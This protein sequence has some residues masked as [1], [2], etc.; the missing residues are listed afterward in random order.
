MIKTLLPAI[1][2]VVGTTA[3]AQTHFSDDFNDVNLTG[4]SSTDN[5]ANV[6][7]ATGTNYDI[8]YAADMSSAFAQLG[9]GS[10]VS[11]SWANNI[12]YSP[13]NF[14]VSPAINLTAA[15]AAGLSLKW[16]VGSI[17]TTAS[18]WYQE[19]YAVYVSTSS[20]P[21]T[22][23][24]TAPVYEETL[25][26]GETMFG[27]TVDLSAF[28][29]QTIYVLFRHFNCTDENALVL[30]NVVVKNLQL[31][32]ASVDGVA[33]NRYAQMSTNNTL[34]VSVKNEGSNAIT[35]LQINWNDGADHIQTING[36][37][38]APGATTNV[39]H[40][41][42]VSYATAV[43]KNI[44][45]T[46]SLV[47]AVVDADPSNNT[48]SA[49]INTVSVLEEKGVV[50][51]EGTGTWCQWCPRG[52]VAMDYMVTTYP[53]DFIG[54]AV[55]NNDPMT[56]A[57]YDNGANFSGFPGSNVDRALLDQSVSQN[58]FVAAYNAR[59]DLIVPAG[60]SVAA[61]GA[62]N[63]VSIVATAT[64][65]TPLAAA[66][67]RLGVIVIED[68]VTGTTSAYNQSNAYAGGANGVMGGYESLP[69][70]VPAAQ[71]V[72]NHV[73]RALLGG[74]SGQAGSVPA[75]ITDG[76]VVNYTFNYT[77][78]GTS[79][80][81]N[82]HAVA[83]LID[84]TNG[85]I[86]NAIQG[87]LSLASLGEIETIGME[88]YPNPATEEVN[89]KFVGTG[90]DYQIIITDLAGRQMSATSLVNVTGAQ[91]VALPISEFGAGNYLVTIAK[92]GA[93]YTQN[94]IVK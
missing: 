80:R 85:E 89:V 22:M 42:A 8:W 59:K 75:V 5:D 71:M 56:V 87:S 50:I 45:V 46:I 79:T 18:T 28:A 62:G 37:N 53:I 19:H 90:G 69:N 86:V 2:L 38:I 23:I 61:T 14:L 54:I 36:L 7:P 91:S 84:Q 94:L 92:D 78:P 66:N 30:D 93:S 40:P 55:H 57:E 68:G 77:V 31:N 67:Y 29:G 39:N 58:A 1:A 16:D 49:K 82:M 32:D 81:A 3:F 64:F 83:V 20:T 43:E 52:A 17:E 10:A 11:R 65:R 74:Y 25:S 72:Y 27:R 12:V 15:P 70:P 76:Q 34:A 51:E 48:G 44:A 88:V 4:W 60:I 24:A 26:A 6:P 47:N 41:T 9:A 63:N 35:S 21:A 33:L 13:N 73:G